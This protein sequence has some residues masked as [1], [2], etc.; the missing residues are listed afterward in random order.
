MAKLPV[1]YSSPFKKS[2][3]MKALPWAQIGL[4]ALPGIISGVGSLF[5]GR[6]R[7]KEQAAARKEMQG[8]KDAYMNMQFKNPFAGMENPYQEN[9]YEDLTVDTQAADYLREQQQQSQANIMQQMKGVAGS[10]G[11]AGLA[12]SMANVGADQAR[13]ASVSISQQERQN[14][15][16]KIKGEQAR[17][18]GSFGFD[19]MMREAQYKTV[20][21]REQQ[22]TENLYGLS[23]DRLSAADKARA[24]ARSG[25]ISGLGQA[26]A[27]VAGTFAPGGVNYGG[28]A[29][30]EQG[31]NFDASQYTDALPNTTQSF[32]GGLGVDNSIGNNNL[33]SFRYDPVTGTYRQF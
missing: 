31:F 33:P 14:E 1:G 32:G 26:A 4:A 25:F 12:Q 24:T 22:R 29:S 13:R 9:L 20:D 17:Q 2:S 15:L 6:K 8:A 5:G 3:P 7:R 28:G 27:G 16:Y 21:L 10:S 19:K 30:T 18:K 11:I 23:L